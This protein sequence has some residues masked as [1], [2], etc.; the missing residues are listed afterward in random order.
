VRSGLGKVS[1]IIKSLIFYESGCF[2]IFYESGCFKFDL[3]DK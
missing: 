1:Y 3:F 2:K